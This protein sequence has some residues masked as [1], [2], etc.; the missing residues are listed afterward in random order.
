MANLLSSGKFDSGDTATWP[1]GD[2]NYDGLL[3]VLDLADFFTTNLFNRGSYRFTAEVS[4]ALSPQS[5][6]STVPTELTASNA[7]FVAFAIE[8]SSNVNRNVKKTRTAVG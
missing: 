2:F 3:D 5:I 8:S 7:V 4:A 1:E 6:K